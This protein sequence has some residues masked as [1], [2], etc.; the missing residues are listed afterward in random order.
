MGNL[1]DPSNIYYSGE[2]IRK[3]PTLDVEDTPWKLKKIIPLLDKFISQ[4]SLTKVKILDVGGGAGLFLKGI[5]DY[6]RTKNINVEQYAL[7]LSAEMLQIQKENNADIK[8]VFVG[9]I[10]KT[11]FKDKE[12]DLVLMI[13]VLEH[14]PDTAA[15]LKEL[16]RISKYVIFKVPLENNLYYNI[17]NLIK[18][19]RL[20]LDIFQKV[21]HLH[22]YTFRKLRRQLE[23]HLGSI[24]HFSVTN[25]FSHLLS[26]GYHRRI[27]I[28]EKIVFSLGKLTFNISPYLCA[29]LFPD[30]V[31]CLVKCR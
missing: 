25:E 15:A 10:E 31:V 27:N 11:S 18:L 19:G 17:L 30:A 1:P 3:N 26:R 4:T 20:R 16:S 9:S 22:F 2:Y 21:G 12:V 23:V 7:D 6:L 8:S 24:L 29:C 13:D 28:K 14:V 5:S